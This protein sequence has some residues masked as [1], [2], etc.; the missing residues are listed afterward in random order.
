[1]KLYHS[2]TSPYVRKV[3]L[4]LYLKGLVEKVQLVP[5]SGTPLAPNRQTLSAN[6]L[7]K[8][9]CLVTDAGEALYDSRVICRYLDSLSGGGLYATDAG[10]FAVLTREAAADGMMDSGIS[11]VYETRL[12][13]PAMQVS[14]VRDAWL[15]KITRT[16]GV[17]EGQAA[18]LDAPVR[19]D[20]IAI[21]SALGYL[22]LRFD[23]LNWRS[24]A[25][26][27]AAWFA[28]FRETP[29]MLA[30]APKE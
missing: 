30:T 26:G 6:P 27:L 18:S 1:M 12:R 3:M 19:I 7:G 9:P 21:A 22:D 13:A 4:V 25:P 16:L 15:A 29:A 28:D 2:A 8:V 23:H 11:A 14:A 24:S 20:H 10:Q 17:L 5:G